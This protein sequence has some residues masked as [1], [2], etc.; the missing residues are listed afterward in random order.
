MNADKASSAA[1]FAGD[2]VGIGVG[3][4]GEG[5]LVSLGVR[6]TEQPKT[7]YPCV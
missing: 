5:G 6:R 2:N 1:I 3:V 4:K 7:L